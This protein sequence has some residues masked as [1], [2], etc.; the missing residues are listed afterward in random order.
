MF[1]K[2]RRWEEKIMITLDNIKEVLLSLGYIDSE[3]RYIYH[4]DEFDC[5]IEVDLKNNKINTWFIEYDCVFEIYLGIWK[6][7]PWNFG[8]CSQKLKHIRK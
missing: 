8:K 6:Q 4:F 5:N 2:V 1:N 3:D 7:C